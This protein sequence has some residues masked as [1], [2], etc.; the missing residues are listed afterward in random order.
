MKYPK[1]N[2]FIIVKGL[3]F[4]LTTYFFTGCFNYEVKKIEINII[5]K[6]LNSCNC[7]AEEL[8]FENLTGLFEYRHYFIIEYNVDCKMNNEI[9]NCNNLDSNLI[10]SIF[11]QNK[12]YNMMYSN[13][14]KFEY[15][16]STGYD[17]YDRVI[18]RVEFDKSNLG[19]KI[20]K[21]M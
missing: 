2:L 3:V 8:K 13:W 9:L 14:E 17:F 7:L 5:N 1:Y 20:L 10:R 18:N 15:S 21:L 19:K 16:D 11:K 4:I 12:L 6:W